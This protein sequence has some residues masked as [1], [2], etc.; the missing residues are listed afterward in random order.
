MLKY[1]F[2]GKKSWRAERVEN[3]SEILTKILIFLDKISVFYATNDKDVSIGR[4]Q[5][6]E[7]ESNLKSS[8]VI[9]L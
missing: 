3:F 7:K 4:L 8:R 9:K 6:E 1:F 5:E 2:G